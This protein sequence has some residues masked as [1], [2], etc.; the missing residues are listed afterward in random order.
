[1]RLLL[2]EMYAPAVAAELRVRGYDVA[3]VHDRAHA[4]LAGAS[5]SDVLAAALREE[6]TLVTENIRD[7]RPPR[8]SFS[9]IAARIT[10]DSSI[11]ATGA[12]RVAI[13]RRRDDLSWRS[14]RF[15]VMRPTCATA[16]SSW[17]APTADRAPHC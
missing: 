17:P 13:Q 14:M 5:D 9:P 6:R 12:S 16:R 15:C 3:S 2:D 11:R 1:M 8:V 4:H 10:P 7:Y